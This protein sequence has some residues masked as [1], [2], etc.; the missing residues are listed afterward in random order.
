MKDTDINI[1]CYE[2]KL[3]FDNEQYGM[4][5]VNH[6]NFGTIAMAKVT[7]FGKNQYSFLSGFH[8]ADKV[9]NQ[10][11][12]KKLLDYILDRARKLEH[13]SM[14]LYVHKDNLIARQ[15]YESRGFRIVMFEDETM[16]LCTKF[17]K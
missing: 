12:G 13:P 7:P 4:F 3:P 16:L 10:G 6:Q 9:R 1:S 5:S 8:V 17:L 2:V 11:V 15:L 14:S